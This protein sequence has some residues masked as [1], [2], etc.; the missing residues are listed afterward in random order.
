M[1]INVMAE[2]VTY[3]F[4]HDLL[5]FF[6]CGAWTGINGLFPSLLSDTATESGFDG[7]LF[8]SSLVKDEMYVAP[9]DANILGIVGDGSID[10]AHAIHPSDCHL[11]ILRKNRAA[12]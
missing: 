3:P 6:P 10:Q 12:Y 2:H 7:P 4:Q 5:R 8:T 1:T 9:R 11:T